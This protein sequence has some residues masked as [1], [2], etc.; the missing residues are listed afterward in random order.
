[1]LAD[2]LFFNYRVPI[3]FQEGEDGMGTLGDG[4]GDGE[5]GGGGGGGGFEVQLGFN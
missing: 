2:P 3:N 1:M 4:S 5:D